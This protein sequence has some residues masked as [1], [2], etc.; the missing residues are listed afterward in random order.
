MNEI[1]RKVDEALAEMV[2]SRVHKYDEAKL[3]TILDQMKMVTR[4]IEVGGH[5]L[6]PGRLEGYECSL[7]GV[8]AHLRHFGQ[9]LT[10][11][12]YLIVYAAVLA[13]ESGKA[14]RKAQKGK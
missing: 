4:A 7:R 13:L 5:S 8:A 10:D 11:E 9:T 2:I 3:A 6:S 12:Q 1:K 14:L